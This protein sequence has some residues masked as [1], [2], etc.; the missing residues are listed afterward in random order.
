VMGQP[1]EQ[2][3]RHLGTGS[4]AEF[5]DAQNFLPRPRVSLLTR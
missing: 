3:R 2:R 5:R 4:E 1:I